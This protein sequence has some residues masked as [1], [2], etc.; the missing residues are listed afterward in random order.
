MY[1]FD[2]IE[3]LHLSSDRTFHGSVVTL[4]NFDG[5]HVGHQKLVQTTIDKAKELNLRS[6]VLSFHPRT[7]EF[8][9][10]T[11]T[12]VTP[13][14]LSETTVVKKLFPELNAYVRASFN[15]N[16]AELS[17]AGF[18]Q[19]YLHGMLQ[20]KVVVVG[21]NF[22]FGKDNVGDIPALKECCAKM[23][24][25]VIVVDEIK[26]DGHSLSSTEI[27]KVL[28]QGNVPVANKMLGYNYFI[29][30]KVEHGDGLGAETH[31]PTINLDLNETNIAL[32]HGVYAAL[33]VVNGKIYHAAMHFGPRPTLSDTYFDDS[34]IRLEAHLLNYDVEGKL[35][36]FE[37]TLIP[38]A[39][40]RDI[41][42]LSG[43]DKLSEQIKEDIKKIRGI[44]ARDEALF[45]QSWLS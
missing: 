9:H 16:I 7:K 11:T 6:I 17:P 1:I 20:A 12:K 43:L 24:I 44:L 35:Y 30:S 19:Q 3:Q 26:M 45:S 32:K 36:E 10:K 41:M 14:E 15:A 40:I 25:D 29:T 22:R 31:F 27:K 37:A 42:K 23:K 33:A 38:V 2:N 13:T 34:V 18:V 21:Y 5:M 4:G 8:F 39:F 28:G